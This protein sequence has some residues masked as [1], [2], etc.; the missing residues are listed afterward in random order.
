MTK[1]TILNIIRTNVVRG[2]VE[3]LIEFLETSDFFTA[4]ASTQFHGSTEGGLAEHSLAVYGILKDKNQAFSLGYSE[5]TIAI[6]GLLHD[7]CKV[8]FYKKKEFES[9]S[10]PQLRYLKSLSGTDFAGQ[11]LSKGTASKLIEQYKGTK[12]GE[13]KNLN[14]P[15]WIV[16]DQLPIGHGE[17]SIFV[18]EKYIHLTDDE[19]MAIR[20]HMISFDPGI[21]FNYPSGFPFRQACEKC[22]LVAAIA[23]SDYES[24]KLLDK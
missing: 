24:D 11:K 22:K 16:D 10:E 17:K 15:E 21:H 20:W 13:I 5:E 19:A 12:A 4:P 6:T 3:Q 1:E 14:A 2:G 9:A 8:N 18:I 7:I 23:T